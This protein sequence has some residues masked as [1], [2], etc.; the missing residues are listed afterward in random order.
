MWPNTEI[1]DTLLPLVEEINFD[2]LILAHLSW[3]EGESKTHNLTSVADDQWLERHVLDSLAPLYAGWELGE[4]FLD[5]GTGAGFPG[6]P[7]AVQGEANRFVFLESKGKVGRILEGFLNESGLSSKGEVLTGRAEELAHQT[8][9]RGKYQ[10]VVVRAVG[11]LSTL[12]EIGAPFLQDGGTLW[13]W[14]SDLVEL[15]QAERAMLELNTEFFRGV[16]YCLPSEEKTRY[17]LAFVRRGEVDKKY[18]RRA[19]VPQKRPL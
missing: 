13:C 1:E 12:I 5:L 4:P 8:E 17:I 10:T 14:K 2:P 15:Q 3:L 19:G 9:Y 18:P 6:I 7:L 16:Q 11:S